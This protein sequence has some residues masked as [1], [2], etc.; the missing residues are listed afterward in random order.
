MNIL[1]VIFEGI[2][3]LIMGNKYVDDYLV[4]KEYF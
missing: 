1:I 3:I 2:F 4:I